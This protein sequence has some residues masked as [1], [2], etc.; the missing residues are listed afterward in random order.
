MTLTDFNKPDPLDPA[1]HRSLVITIDGPA[2]AGKST[3]AKMLAAR[4]GFMFLDT[5]AMYRCVTL[6]VLRSGISL[7]DSKRIRELVEA[8]QIRLVDGQVFLN[9]DDVTEEIRKP[10]V[11]AAIGLVADNVDVRTRLTELQRDWTQGKQVVT[12]GRDQG[13]QVFVDSPCKIYLYA[14]AAER[15][16]RRKIEMASRGIE[17]SFK[18]V[19][20][21]QEKRDEEDI[22]RPFG[23]LKK[24]KDALEICT[25]DLPL[26]E[27]VEM[28]L[29]VVKDRLGLVSRTR[30]GSNA[31]QSQNKNARF[32]EA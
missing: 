19:L 29:V 25:D 3:V 32:G 23:A 5:G 17:M 8:I 26:E 10:K 6:A 16:R 31:K 21:Q 28:L 9:A 12:E 18:D 13:S 30:S 7:T 24:A 22:S 1:D 20:A 14:S 15:A 4:L 11:A 27:V 2:G